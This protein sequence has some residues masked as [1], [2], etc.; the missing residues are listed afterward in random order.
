MPV[1][2]VEPGG[3]RGDAVGAVATGHA[4][5]DAVLAQLRQCGRGILARTL[6][7]AEPRQRTVL[8][9]QHQRRTGQSRIV[10]MLAQRVAG[11]AQP[12]RSAV[13]V[14]FD[15]GGHP[16]A[17]VLC[18]HGRDTLACGGA[19][20]AGQRVRAGAGQRARPDQHLFGRVA[21][22]RFGGVAV[23]ARGGERAGLVEQG[24]VHVSE[25]EQCVA[26]GH[27]HLATGEL[28]QRTGQ[29]H[30]HGQREGAGAGHYQHGDGGV[31]RA[32]GVHRQPAERREHDK[33]H[34]ATHEAGD[35]GIAAGNQGTRL[36]RP[37]GQG[38]EPGHAGLRATVFHAQLRRSGEQDAAGDQSLAAAA[39]LRTRFAGQQGFVH[40][41]F[42]AFQHA[43]GGHGAAVVD[44]HAV[45]VGQ[46][47]RG[48]RFQFAVG[49]PAL[50]Q[51]R[52]RVQQGIAARIAAMAR[53]QFQVTRA[54]QQEHEHADRIE[55]DLAAPAQR[56]DHAGDEHQRDGQGHWQ[57]DAQ[58]P[59][60]QL[61]GGAPEEHMGRIEHQRDRGQQAQPAEQAAR[62]E[63]DEVDHADVAHERIGHYLHRAHAGDQDALE[64][65]VHLGG[66][67]VPGLI[68]PQRARRAA[69]GGELLQQRGQRGTP[70][71]PHHA[72]AP[73]GTVH[74]DPAH[75][76]QSVDALLQPQHLSGI[77]QRVDVQ[78]DLAQAVAPLAQHL[79]GEPGIAP[80]RRAGHGRRGGGSV[81]GWAVLCAA[82]GTPSTAC[83]VLLSGVSA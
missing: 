79:G 71:I 44:V 83:E 69:G 33:D 73:G 61:V 4:H 68:P 2:D 37:R 14:A 27:Q 66:A 56:V 30:R 7:E 40:L 42:R 9:R 77:V 59:A 80:C 51:Q 49:A 81:E 24:A 8:V 1:V 48:D 74:A 3:Q 46:A 10:V 18:C 15:A 6:V 55:I 20:R 13:Q 76:G 45:A 78:G 38:A 39:A 64:R 60:A 16:H 65:I 32:R 28:P 21:T 29:R 53:A 43:V 62:A 35:L 34:H 58:A 17:Y 19:Q 63:V 72:H 31:E 70:R 67:R 5:A 12:Q 75:A 36:A 50:G 82:T 26:V 57:V 11:T 52:S 23:Q 47:D 41:D 22:Q 25:L 54:Q